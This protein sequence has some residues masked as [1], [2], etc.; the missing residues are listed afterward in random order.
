[1]ASAIPSSGK[2]GRGSVTMQ[3]V[4][5]PPLHLHISAAPLPKEG[6]HIRIYFYFFKSFSFFLVSS[7][8][9]ILNALVKAS[10]AFFFSPAAT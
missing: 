7:T 2:G 3:T 1:M 4:Q 10:M 6:I 9:W 5:T 8:S